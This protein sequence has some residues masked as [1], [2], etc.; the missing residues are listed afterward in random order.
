MKKYFLISF[1]SFVV[2]SGSICINADFTDKLLFGIKGGANLAS[3]SFSKEPYSIYKQETFVRPLFGAF[4]ESNITTNVS[5]RP[6]FLWIGRGVKIDDLGV[7]Y[8]F[9]PNY[10]D[11]RLPFIYN[12]RMS[13]IT[14][15]VLLSPNFG[16]VT[17][18]KT[19]RWGVKD[20]N[21]NTGKYGY[22]NG[23][24]FGISAG[25]GVKFPIP[26]GDSRFYLGIEAQYN[27]GLIN[28][29]P[30]EDYGT[31]SNRG[32]EIAATISIPLGGKNESSFSPDKVIYITKTR[33]DTIYKDR[34]VYVDKDCYEIREILSYL[35]DGYNVHNK[36]IC[37]YNIQFD[38]NKS[39]VN[40]ESR[41]QL[42]EIVALL[43]KM[44]KMEM[45]INGHADNRG[46]KKVNDEISTKRAKSVYDYLIS[47]GI[48]K[49][50][51]TY[52]GFGSNKPIASND[53]EKGREQNRRVEFE[54]TQ[55]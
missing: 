15:Y 24:D 10:F 52:A 19:T 49:S 6:E 7:E 48:D 38:F 28:N 35:E 34:I 54:I 22:I 32:I 47:K 2:L 16:F 41:P 45:K 1:L 46:D 8:E 14:P 11:F 3:M 51:L 37:L 26:L 13:S 42:D 21:M 29:K 40:P 55:Y 53:T 27:F 5:V 9:A 25:A 36:R 18:G 4:I 12:F 23:F 17:G 44:P 33:T 31:R 43:Q 30:N 20:D 50:R 39:T